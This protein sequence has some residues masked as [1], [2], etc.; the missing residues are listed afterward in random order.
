[1]R[2]MIVED[3]AAMRK[4]LL[5]VFSRAG[6]EVVGVFEDGN[7]LEEKIQQANP[8]IVCL[9]YNLPGRDGLAILKSIQ[10]LAPEIDVL[11]MTASEE[12]GLEEKAADAG[13]AGFIRKPFSQTQIVDELQVVAETRRLAKAS[14]LENKSLSQGA[15]SVTSATTRGTAVIADDNGSIR[16][17]LNALLKESRMKVVQ[18]VSNGA[19][20][21]LAAKNHQP[22]VLFLDINMPVMG[23]MEAL[24]LIRAASP[25]TAV[26]M[27]TGCVD[28][29]QVTQA[30]GLG[31][32][33][34]IIKPLRPAY[35][36]N[37]I[38]K[39]LGA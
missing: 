12:S 28:K 25:N 26:V 23:G 17:I 22:A 38:R 13:A 37:F 33:G 5:S 9:D 34:Y 4:V 36:E 31:A 14:A 39:L 15:G 1:M 21:V 27:V 20:A 8:D 24:P 30:A 7:G 35:V 6:Y 32:V 18:S 2:I 16:L 3:N 11:F 10:S 29:Q 19:E